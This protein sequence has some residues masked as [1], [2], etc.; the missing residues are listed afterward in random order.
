VDAAILR[1]AQHRTRSL[2]DALVIEAPCRQL[3]KTN[4]D[5]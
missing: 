5:F 3:H 2:L 4:Q 1:S